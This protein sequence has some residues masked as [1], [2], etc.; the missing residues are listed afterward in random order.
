M[1][2]IEKRKKSIRLYLSI[3]RLL[4]EF[5]TPLYLFY[6]I[7]TS[8]CNIICRKLVWAET[9]KLHK[10][11]LFGKYINLFVTINCT[12]KMI[13]EK[14]FIGLTQLTPQSSI[15]YEQ[16]QTIHKQW[17]RMHSLDIIRN[18]ML[19]YKKYKKCKF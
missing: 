13:S 15:T 10:D 2:F 9:R 3:L 17:L 7:W 1:L 4:K 18:E 14:Y 6:Y 12:K 16:I 5:L 11:T 19:K 8:I